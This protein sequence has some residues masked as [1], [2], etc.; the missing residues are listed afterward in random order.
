[1]WW[2]QEQPGLRRWCGWLLMI[3]IL[4]LPKNRWLHD[5]LSSSTNYDYFFCSF[6][7]NCEA[8]FHSSSADCQTLP[9]SRWS[10]KKKTFW[11]RWRWIKL[12]K[13]HHLEW[14]KHIYLFICC[15]LTWSTRARLTQLI[16][17]LTLSWSVWIYCGQVVYVARNPKDVIVSYFHH[18]KL[19]TNQQ[20]TADIEKFAD[21]FMKDECKH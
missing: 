19:F 12:G 16:K 8:H 7:V 15:L 17:H 13:C 10:P 6:L 4:K 5:L 14:S 9:K 21:Y 2:W 11:N 1:M 18:H 20:F 3:V